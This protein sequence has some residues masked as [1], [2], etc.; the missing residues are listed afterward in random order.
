MF[1]M[2]FKTYKQPID[3]MYACAPTVCDDTC[4]NN[5]C[6]ADG[7]LCQCPA[8]PARLWG[9]DGTSKF[10]LYNIQCSEIFTLTNEKLHTEA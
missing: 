1:I 7:Y 4:G 6:D 2:P 3:T 8:C 10:I 9:A 5:D